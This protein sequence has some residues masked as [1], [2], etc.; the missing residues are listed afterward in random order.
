MERLNNAIGGLVP[1]AQ[2]QGAVGL[3]GAC[4]DVALKQLQKEWL[5]EDKTGHWSH[6]D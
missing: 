4:I 6:Y 2:R 5:P 1:G 3:A